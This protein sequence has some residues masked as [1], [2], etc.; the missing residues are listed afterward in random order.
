MHG[1]PYAWSSICMEQAR[2]TCQTL[3]QLNMF[4]LKSKRYCFSVMSLYFDSHIIMGSLLHRSLYYI[5]ILF[6]YI[7][8]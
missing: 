1:A 7:V 5:S 3:D 2:G 4:K 6:L 8:H